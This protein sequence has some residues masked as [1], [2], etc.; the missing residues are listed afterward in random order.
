MVSLRK[1]LSCN[2]I[3]RYEHCIL[4]DSRYCINMIRVL[5]VREQLTLSLNT[6]HSSLKR[7]S[8]SMKNQYKKR[9]II[10]RISIFFAFHVNYTGTKICLARTLNMIVNIV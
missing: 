3:G 6:Q 7:A 5:A 10:I 8:K 2:G 4:L 1:D 9:A